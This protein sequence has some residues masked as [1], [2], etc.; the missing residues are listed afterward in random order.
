MRNQAAV[1][2]VQ[3]S[4][5]ACF[6]LVCT[7]TVLTTQADAWCFASQISIAPVPSLVH[8]SCCLL[9]AQLFSSGQAAVFLLGSPV[10]VITQKRLRRQLPAWGWCLLIFHEGL[11][12]VHL[13]F[14]VVQLHH[15]VAYRLVLLVGCCSSGWHTVPDVLNCT[16]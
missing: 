2:P 6:L 1:R 14:T 3:V 8:G 9:C 10:D 7:A 5:Q 16:E 15:S 12:D 11:D 13:P 4:R